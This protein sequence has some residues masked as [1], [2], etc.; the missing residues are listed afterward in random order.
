MSERYRLV[1][2]GEVL[3]GQHAA[4]VRKR[5][6][7]AGS[8]DEAQL[9]ALFSGNPVIVKRE[10]EPDAAA[11]LQALFRKAGARLRVQP[12]QGGDGVAPGDAG[13]PTWDLL[14]AGSDLLREEERARQDPVE[15]DA[16]RLARLTVAEVGADLLERRPEKHV[17]APDVSHLRLV[18][19][20]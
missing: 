20:P 10:A 7:Q 6:G 1:F 13:T 17:A 8:F 12:V 19:E 18:D 14:P 9:D 3:E 2:R 4:V 11:R 5:L 15:V 16:G